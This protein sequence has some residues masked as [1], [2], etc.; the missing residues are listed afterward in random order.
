MKKF[1]TNK[2]VLDL[3]QKI[4]FKQPG[5]GNR[6]FWKRANPPFFAKKSKKRAICSFCALLLFLKRAKERFALFKR[7]KERLALW[8]S[9]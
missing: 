5:L 9:F 6:S 8:R 4:F 3:N 7:A 1:K 2:N